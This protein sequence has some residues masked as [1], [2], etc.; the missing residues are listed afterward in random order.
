MI[1]Q[2]DPSQNRVAL[3]FDCGSDFGYTNQILSTLANHDVAASFGLTGEWV[4]S[5]TEGA[6]K[7]AARGYQLINHTLD[8]PSFTGLSTPGTSPAS[9]AR[10]LAQIQANETLIRKVTG[11]RTRPY[12]R[13]PFGDL[14]EG[15][16][17]DVGA[18]G[19]SQT[20]LWTIDSFG[21][22]NLT[23]HEIYDWVMSNMVPGAIVLM[24]VGAQSQDANAIDRIIRSL[25][26]MRYE[27]VT[28]AGMIE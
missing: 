20:A 15:V 21:W 7:I 16:L 24:H 6:E 23:H 9:P 2:G 14:D 1:V 3:T 17:R 10:R 13:P 22:N 27:F 4:E 18:L 28:V 19:F 5:N 26:A 11:K 25:K 8:H 12:W